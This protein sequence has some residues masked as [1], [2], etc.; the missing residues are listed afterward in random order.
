MV[1]INKKLNAVSNSSDPQFL[2]NL[3]KMPLSAAL[4]AELVAAYLM[5]P[6]DSGSVDLLDYEPKL[7]Y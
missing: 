7:V 3:K 6:V 1:E 5:P 4:L 2:K